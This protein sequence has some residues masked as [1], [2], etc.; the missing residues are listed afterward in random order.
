MNSKIEFLVYINTNLHQEILGT[1][2][3]NYLQTNMGSATPLTYKSPKIIFNINYKM[4]IIIIISTN[5]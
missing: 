4:N 3:K 1:E 2:R 5:Q